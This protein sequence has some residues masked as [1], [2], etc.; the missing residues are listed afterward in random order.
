MS[1]APAPQTCL[2]TGKTASTSQRSL[3]KRDIAILQDLSALRFATAKDIA[4]LHFTPHSLTY[5]R[6]RAS[7]LAGNADQK[8]G[9]YLYRMLPPRTT[10]GNAER[11][12]AL[13][14]KGAQALTDMT[15]MPVSCY[16][17]SKLK[18]VSFSFLRHALLVTRIVAALRYFVR[19]HTDYSLLTCRLFYELARLRLP[20]TGEET[21][22]S[23]F[24]PVIPDAWGQLAR[25]DGEETPLWIEAD[26]GTEMRGKFHAYLKARIAFLQ[27]DYARVFG[28]PAVLMCFLT[29]GHNEDYKDVRR[30]ALQRWTQEVLA[31]RK[32]EDWADVFRFAALGYQELFTSP[33]FDAAIWYCA[34]SQ[35]AVPLVTPLSS[36]NS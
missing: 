22:K 12:Y 19:T 6:E 13:G 2:P 35:T 27:T 14:S 29:T 36:D 3:T 33:V 23:P 24:L 5:G 20:A 16:Y 34:D 25:S 32:L 10:S 30:Q 31:A 11:I 17:P 4:L 15:G 7:S 21:S 9:E 28:T 1:P 8:E 18:G 26:C